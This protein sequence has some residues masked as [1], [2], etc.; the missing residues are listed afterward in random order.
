MTATRASSFEAMSTTTLYGLLRLRSEVFVVEQSCPYL[1]MDGRDKESTTRHVWIEYDDEPVACLRLTAD[2]A[3]YQIGR[4]CTAPQH[5]GS[6]LAGRLMTTALQDIH[7]T[8]SLNSQSYATGFYARYGFKICGDSFLEDGIPH[9][10]MQH[11]IPAQN[12]SRGSLSER[13]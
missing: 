1:D 3:G 8:V 12:N 13:D 11:I 10:P 9:V 5:R 2:A 6:G 7:G 4:V